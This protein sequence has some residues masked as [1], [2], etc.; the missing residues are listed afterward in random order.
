[1]KSEREKRRDSRSR[2]KTGIQ[3]YSAPGFYALT[4]FLHLSQLSRPRFYAWA[5]A[6]HFT[7]S[8]PPSASSSDAIHNAKL[9]QAYTDVWWNAYSQHPDVLA[10]E[11][12]DV[13]HFRVNDYQFRCFGSK[14]PN[15]LL[16]V[17][18]QPDTE[19]L[20]HQIWHLTSSRSKR[21][22]KITLRFLAKAEDVVRR[23]HG[24]DSSRLPKTAFWLPRGKKSRHYFDLAKTLTGNVA[25]SAPTVHWYRCRPPLPYLPVTPLNRVQ[26]RD[27]NSAVKRRVRKAVRMAVRK[28]FQR[29]SSIDVPDFALYWRGQAKKV[30]RY[31]L[32][33]RR[34]E[35]KPTPNWVDLTSKRTFMPEL[36]I[37][38]A[39][40]RKSNVAAAHYRA[41][42]IG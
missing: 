3:L 2:R 41:D 35:G 21:L 39:A 17:A 16:L 24:Q 36:V 32:G 15:L 22:D 37:E 42:G 8:W 9:Y 29:F 40:G 13:L 27:P 18:F 5:K 12:A 26:L 30:T 38:N 33:A 25:V 19:T 1:M 34:R 11:Q 4:E 28:Q 10:A 20:V 6:L 23:L 7:W 14:S 31:F